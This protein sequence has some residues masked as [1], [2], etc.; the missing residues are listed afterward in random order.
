ML[1]KQLKRTDELLGHL[2]ETLFIHTFRQ[3]SEEDVRI[4]TVHFIRLLLGDN[5]D[6]S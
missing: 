6:E 5:L 3:S 1:S 4:Q 2:T